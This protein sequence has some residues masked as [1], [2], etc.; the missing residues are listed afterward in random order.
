MK[1]AFFGTPQLSAD[2]LET[3]K[4]HGLVPSVVVTNP[5]RPQGRK[6]TLTSPPVKQWALAND[7]PCLQPESP[8]D[9]DFLYKLKAKS[10]KLFIVVA[11]GSILPKELLALP[12]HGSLNIHYSLLPKYRGASPIESQILADDRKTGVSILLLDEAMD[13]GPLVAEKEIL[14]PTWPPTS[15]QLRMESNRIA[16]ELLADVLPKWVAGDI[17]AKSQDHVKA[18]YTKKFRKSD[19]QL[20]LADDPYQNFLKICAFESSI[21]TYFFTERGERRIRVSIKSAEFREN[22]LTITRVVPEGRSEMAYSDFLR[23]F[24]T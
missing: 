4:R 15:S 3:L 16:G 18:T 9:P 20:D 17:V 2:I 22:R 14:M 6:M 12:T 7:I 5:D 24:S 23:G 13:H 19:G 11:Y 1:F 21:G 8:S 10:Y